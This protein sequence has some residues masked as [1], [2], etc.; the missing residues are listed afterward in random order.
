MPGAGKPGS[1]PIRDTP[2]E[3]G[4]EDNGWQAERQQE[5]FK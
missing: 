1:V 3:W 5:T 2:Q 4:F